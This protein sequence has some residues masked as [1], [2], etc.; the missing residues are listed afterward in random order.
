MSF[1]HVMFRHSS[2]QGEYRRQLSGVGQHGRPPQAGVHTRRRQHC[3]GVKVH[4]CQPA[5]GR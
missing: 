1:K 3:R 2:L 4:L 5:E